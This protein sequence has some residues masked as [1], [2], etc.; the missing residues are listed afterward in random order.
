M[1][2]YIEIYTDGACRGNPGVG[3]WGVVIIDGAERIEFSGFEEETTNNRMEMIA[4]IKA[5]EY[6]DN[7]RNVLIIT[8]SKYLM[9]GIQ[10]WLPDWKKR[11]WKTASKKPVK[12]KD[13]WQQLDK[14]ANKHKLE[15]RWV[16]GHTGNLG[17]ERA[18]MLANQAIDTLGS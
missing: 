4:A 8:D 10:E 11:G 13:L 5:L 18:D 9:Q 6:L 7:D 1:E 15:W 14:L 17:N 16:K 3:G 12:N 2:N